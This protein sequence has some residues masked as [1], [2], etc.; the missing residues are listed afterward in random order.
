MPPKGKPTP[1]EREPRFVGVPL[2]DFIARTESQVA[3][4]AYSDGMEMPPA[5]REALGNYV[6]A[7]QASSRKPRFYVFCWS[8]GCFIELQP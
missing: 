7:V 4:G 2:D 1:V 6:K 5:H 8:L 3:A